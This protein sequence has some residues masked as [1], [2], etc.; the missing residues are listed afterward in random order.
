S[1]LAAS[2]GL[3]FVGAVGGKAMAQDASHAAAHQHGAHMAHG[4][5]SLSGRLYQVNPDMH[6]HNDIAHDPAAIPPPITRREPQT[7]RVDLETVELEAHLDANSTF[8]FWTF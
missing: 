2:A 6:E 5:Q 4:S 7:V 3:T 8:R 1:L